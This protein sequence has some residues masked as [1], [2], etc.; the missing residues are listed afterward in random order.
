MEAQIVT[1]ESQCHAAYIYHRCSERLVRRERHTHAHT[2]TDFVQSQ[3]VFAGG[4]LSPSRT[5]EVGC[6]FTLKDIVH[7]DSDQDMPED[8]AYHIDPN[9]PEWGQRALADIASL[10]SIVRPNR[11]QEGPKQEAAADGEKKDKTEKKD[12]KDKKDKKKKKKKKRDSDSSSSSSEEED[13][14]ETQKDKYVLE[15]S[16]WDSALLLFTPQ[17]GIAVSLYGMFLLLVNLGLQAFFT[18]LVLTK[19]TDPAFSDGDITELR[20]WRTNIAH[21]LKYLDP[22]A[23]TSLGARVCSEDS[24]VEMSGLQAQYVEELN[25]YLEQFD[26]YTTIA[27]G[28]T[29]GGLVILICCFVWCITILK[30]INSNFRLIKAVWVNVNCGTNKGFAITRVRAVLFSAVQLARL[31]VS[32]L[33]LYAGVLYLGQHTYSIPD[34]LLNMV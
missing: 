13:E 3:Q 19:L 18:Q 12:K 14:N 33:L 25:A 10:K 5:I 2:L 24:G 7:H 32:S 30:D 11:K 26:G 29:V 34:L 20:K 9:I 16:I 28:Y 21:D 15:E 1:P 31:T 17:V 23:H 4:S 6:D 8:I 27:D 22:F